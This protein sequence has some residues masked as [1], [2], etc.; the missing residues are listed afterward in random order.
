M[1]CVESCIDTMKL[2]SYCSHVRFMFVTFN[3]N[4]SYF[5]I[6]QI[7]PEKNGEKIEQGKGRNYLPSL[8]RFARILQQFTLSDNKTLA[9]MSLQG[10]GECNVNW[11]EVALDV[12]VTF[13]VI[14]SRIFAP[15]TW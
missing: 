11:N 6:L 10:P 15:E 9:R 1:K 7:L 4:F 5:L 2:Y 3:L 14:R 13:N 12:A 8:R